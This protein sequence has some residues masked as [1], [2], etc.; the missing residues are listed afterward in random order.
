MILN[1]FSTIYGTFV[2]DILKAYSSTIGAGNDLHSH[3]H[4]AVV[5]SE[6]L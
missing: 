1:T 4:T 5:A 3:L 6:N 2:F